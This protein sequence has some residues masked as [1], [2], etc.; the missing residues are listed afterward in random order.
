MEM[1]VRHPVHLERDSD[2]M[3]LP[4][5][6]TRVSVSTGA[7]PAIGNR[8]L[9]RFVFYTVSHRVDVHDVGEYVSPHVASPYVP[10]LR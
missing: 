4:M 6:S 3:Y 2:A 10:R 1:A 5:S 9:S 7:L 8:L